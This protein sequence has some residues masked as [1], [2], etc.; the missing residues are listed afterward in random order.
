MKKDGRR[1]AQF[2]RFLTPVMSRP[3]LETGL[4]RRLFS[5]YGMRITKL[6]FVI[7][8]E[9]NGIQMKK[10]LIVLLVIGCGSAWAHGLHHS[11]KYGE[12][13]V[14][15]LS[16][17]NGTAFSNKDY[18][19]YRAGE[20][21]PYQTGST[22]PFGRISFIPDSS[23]TWR[24]R[25][26]SKDGHGADFSID[27]ET[28]VEHPDTSEAPPDTLEK[29]V[30]EDRVPIGTGWRILMAVSLLFGVFG[31]VSIFMRKRK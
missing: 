20:S 12:S 23:G 28:R 22:D 16:Y 6:I 27:T 11:V 18:E 31:V 4:D 26:F 8:P 5:A 7:P 19:I 15:T 29:Q 17:S 13:V 2:F 1:P 30:T 10:L 21:L 24:I 3:T 9:R 25:T 14:I